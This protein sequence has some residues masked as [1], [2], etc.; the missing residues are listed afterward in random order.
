MA[1]FTNFNIATGD[2]GNY[3][4]WREDGVKKNLSLGKTSLKDV[5]VWDLQNSITKA[6]LE[7][8]ASKKSVDVVV[9]DSR[10][11]KVL[12]CTL[13]IA[14]NSRS[15]KPNIVESNLEILTDKA[16][17]EHNMPL[18]EIKDNVSTTKELT[19]R[20]DNTLTKI[21]LSTNYKC[22]LISKGYVAKNKRISEVTIH[23]NNESYTSYSNT[24]I[25]VG[26]VLINTDDDSIIEVISEESLIRYKKMSE[27]YGEEVSKR[28]REAEAAAKLEAEKKRI[29]EMKAKPWKEVTME[30]IEHESLNGLPE[31]DEL[32]IYLMNFFNERYAGRDPR[33]IVLFKYKITNRREHNAHSQY[34]HTDY[35]GYIA[36][37]LPGI[38]IRKVTAS[39]FFLKQNVYVSE[40]SVDWDPEITHSI[41]Y[42]Y[43]ND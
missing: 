36:E 14:I 1:E 40:T 26:H 25:V 30:T 12:K 6:Q 21:E 37:P 31:D 32:Y 15:H 42:T 7:T 4:T 9:K 28:A 11:G 33:N 29:E 35:S 2:Y 10:K 43:Y 20:I 23:E 22:S 8:L 5:H 38:D 27:E 39:R 3:F 13:S 17:L 16:I 19:A 34:G 41:S 18:F 24:K